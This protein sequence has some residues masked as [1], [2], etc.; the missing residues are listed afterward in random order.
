MSQPLR[1]ATFLLLTLSAAGCIGGPDSESAAA[2]LAL[3]PAY[4]LRID[5][6]ITVQ[7][8]PPGRAPE[9]PIEIHAAIRGLLTTASSPSGSVTGSFRLCK[10][11]LP[12]V[13]GR[14]LVFED[15]VWSRFQQDPVVLQPTGVPGSWSV[16]P[17]AI[18]MGVRDLASPA[19]DPLPTDPNDPRVDPVEDDRPG[20]RIRIQVPAWRDPKI[21][22][23]VRV[24]LPTGNVAVA[25]D[26]R[27]VGEVDLVHD[28]W[29]WYADM[30]WPISDRGADDANT[31]MRDKMLEW[32]II[33]QRHALS[34]LPLAGAGNCTQALAFADL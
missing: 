14:Q 6:D 2:G 28:V 10:L 7:H 22:A 32:P 16:S 21:D 19:D 23:T 4:A 5:S 29:V 8:T 31:Y 1:S 20:V 9:T 3:A 34:G 13:S 18:L 24:R 17:W 33:E 12:P 15:D 26:G 25:P 27:L 30:P 11:D